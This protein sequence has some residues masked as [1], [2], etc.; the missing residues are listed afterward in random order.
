MFVVVSNFYHAC[1]ISIIYCSGD[2]FMFVCLSELLSGNYVYSWINTYR[3]WTNNGNIRQCSNKTLCV[4]CTERT[5][6]VLSLLFCLF[7]L[8]SASVSALQ[9][10]FSKSLYAILTL[11]LPWQVFP[12]FFL[13]CKA[14]ARVKLA[15]TGHGSHCSQLGYN[16]Y[17]VSSSLIL[18]WL[19]G[20]W[21]PES[22]PTKVVNCVVLCIV[23]V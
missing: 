3:G 7:V 16:F 13:S 19:R 15:K 22:L 9:I 18:F 20:D 23:C 6:M 11:R 8:C 10:V 1:D 5:L 17:A 12:C 14:N 4:G 2:G 21:V